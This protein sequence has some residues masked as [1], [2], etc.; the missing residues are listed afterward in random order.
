MVFKRR[1]GVLPAREEPALA[2]VAVV[3]EDALGPNQKDASVQA[4]Y[5]AVVTHIVVDHLSQLIT[6]IKSYITSEFMLDI[7]IGCM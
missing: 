6:L 4:K 3:G 1:E 5:P 2:V 7:E